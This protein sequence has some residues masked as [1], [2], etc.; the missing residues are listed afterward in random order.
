MLDR[1]RQQTAEDSWG[2]ESQEQGSSTDDG[3]GVG[4]AGRSPYVVKRWKWES[5]D[6][7]G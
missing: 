3:V 4:A 2:L 7:V 6:L 5:G 1:E